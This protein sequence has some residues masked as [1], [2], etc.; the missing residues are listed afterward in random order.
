MVQIRL[1]IDCFVDF[2]DRTM[3]TQHVE[4][5]F[6]RGFEAVIEVQCTDQ[7]FECIS[8]HRFLDIRP[9]HLRN[10]EA[11]KTE[12]R[13]EK[14]ESLSVDNLRFA[15]RQCPFL[16]GRERAKEEACDNQIKHRIAQEFEPFIRHAARRVSVQHRRM[17]ERFIVVIPV[18]DAEPELRTN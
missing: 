2:I 8:D 17:A 13:A 16:F 14:V 18:P 3:P 5:G 1:E 12:F 15:L 11:R 4:Y 10:D 9:A 7:G 6:P